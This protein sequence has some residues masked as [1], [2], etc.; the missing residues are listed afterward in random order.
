MEYTFNR[1]EYADSAVLFDGCQEQPL[2]LDVSL[3]DYCPDIQRILKCQ[4]TPCILGHSISGDR[5]EIDGSV[6]VRVLYL[7]SREDTV[8]CCEMDSG[9]SAAIPLRE[10]GVRPCARVSAR[11]EYVNCR[12]TSPRRLDIHGAFSV[13]ALVVEP[14]RQQL[15]TCAMEEELEQKRESRPASILTGLGEQS[16]TI[17]EMLEVNPGKPPV[18]AILRSRACCILQDFRPV[19]GKLLAKGMVRLEVLYASAL[20]DGALETMDFEIPF[21]QMVDC[22][23][24]EEDCR[25]SLHMEAVDHA[26]QI[27]SDTSG[28]AMRLEAEVRIN[29]FACAYRDEELTF[30]TDAYSTRYETD[31]DYSQLQ[32]SCLDELIQES[33]IQKTALDAGAPL[34]QVLDVWNE[35]LTVSGEVQDGQLHFSGKINLCILAADSQGVPFYVEKMADFALNRPW[36]GSDG[37]RVSCWAQVEGLGYRIT[38]NSALEVTAEISVWGTASHTAA[39]KAVSGI[40]GDENRCKNEGQGILCLYYACEN[41]SLWDIARSHGVSLQ[42]LCEENGL[43]DPDAGLTEGQMLLLTAQ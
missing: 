17:S 9:F 40:H 41:E 37:S 31:L 1:A 33:L 14:N 22:G 26:L 30:I 10:P 25:C 13:C 2:D 18:E 32:V 6:R 21:S 43:S 15:C 3:P 34:A 11:V 42:A 35:V 39:I 23:G 38:G 16:F 7:D 24:A 19:S 4:V 8:R 20:E 29:A 36:N 27:R 5:L 12:A 28:E